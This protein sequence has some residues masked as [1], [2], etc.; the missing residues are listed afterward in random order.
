MGLGKRYLKVGIENIKPQALLLLGGS[1]G[2]GSALLDYISTKTDLICIPTYNMNRPAGENFVWQ[3]YDSSNV[4]STRTLFEEVSANFQ[5]K[6]VIDATGS[7][8]AAKL[9]NA[10]PVEISKVIFTN[11]IAPMILAKNCQEFMATEGRVVFLSSILSK[12]DLVGSSVYASSK[13]GLERGI[14][15]LASEYTQ[16]GHAIC[17][18]RLGYMD[19]GMTYKINDRVRGEILRSLPEGKFI[20]ISLLGE[21]ILELCESK[22]K[23]INGKIYEIK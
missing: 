14:Q 16:T 5:V 13:A 10:P 1:G 8:F 21:K 3:Q 15:V 7:F 11:L 2:I 19:Y 20:D 4:D 22:A 18:I 23:V 12:M 17:G 6:V 9:R